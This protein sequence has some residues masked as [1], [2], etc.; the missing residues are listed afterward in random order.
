MADLDAI[1]SAYNEITD[2]KD[3]A[4]EVTLAVV[5]VLAVLFRQ[6]V[7]GA[8]L[9]ERTL[10][11]ITNHVMTCKE[12]LFKDPEIEMFF[13]EEMQKAMGSVSNVELEIFAKIIMQT[14]PYQS[15][16][17]DLKGLLN[18]YVAHITSEKPF[19]RGISA[20]PLLEFIGANVL[21][22]KAFS[23]LADKQKTSILR[24]YVD[25]ITTGHPSASTLKT[26]GKLSTDI[27]L[28][29][30]PAEQESTAIIEFTQVECL[31]NVLY[32]LATKEPELIEKED[33]T[34]RFRNLYM[35]TQLQISNV[36][37][38]LTT[39]QAKQPQDAEQAATIKGL[40]KTI[41]IHSNIHTVVKEFLKPKHLRSTKLALH[42]SWKPLPE[43]VKPA[44]P[45]K[46]A[47][48]VAGGKATLTAAKPATTGTGPKSTAVTGKAGEKA[49]TKLGSKAMPAQQQ[50]QQQQQQQPPQ[51][52]HGGLNKRKSEQE[53]SA[54]PK[55][56]KIVRRHGSNVGGGSPGSSSPGGHGGAGVSTQP[57]QGSHS[58]RG[59]I[60]RGQG[61][62]SSSFDGR[63]GRESNG[64]I[65]FLK[66]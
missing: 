27:L 1:Y 52:Q 53:A 7:K 3:N 61:S 18:S 42:P 33:L 50:Q 24:L 28:A 41:A 15:G 17:L 51:Q 20:D 48:P 66:R 35:S 45:V 19:D 29:V 4:A 44:G 31:T 14:R 23:Q 6:G 64:K 40:K 12:A 46:P 60:G 43:P 25:S 10:D 62:P 16:E 21:P 26:A 39:A 22:L 57:M 47:K 5:E 37:Q 38:A 36:R 58:K 65:N 11:F 32:L 55:K 59:S 30:V 34:R 2:A 54:K 8:D 63:R 49:N 56:P 9:R 13:L